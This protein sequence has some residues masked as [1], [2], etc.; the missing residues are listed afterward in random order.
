MKNKY[1]NLITVT[2]ADLQIIH[3]TIGTNKLWFGI[4]NKDTNSAEGSQNSS[5]FEILV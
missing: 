2:T 4:K 1:W 5:Q 3:T